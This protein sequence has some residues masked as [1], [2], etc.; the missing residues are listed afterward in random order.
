[1]ELPSGTFLTMTTDG[2]KEFSCHE[3]IRDFL[4]IPMYFADPYSSWKRGSNENDNGLLCESF[5]KGSNFGMI[6]KTELNHAL[7]RINNRLRKCLDCSSSSQ[8]SYLYAPQRGERNVKNKRLL[9]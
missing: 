5:S 2:G 9:L 4:G 7:S 3:R 8:T 6:N 1:M